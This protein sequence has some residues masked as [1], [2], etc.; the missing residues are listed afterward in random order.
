MQ[1]Q[2]FH[3][4]VT[5]RLLRNITFYNNNNK[6]NNNNNNNNKRNLHH[7]IT[8]TYLDF[9][10]FV[11]KKTQKENFQASVT[12]TRSHKIYVCASNNLSFTAQRMA[13]FSVSLSSVFLSISAHT[14][15][16]IQT[17][18]LT[19]CCRSVCSPCWS[20]IGRIHVSSPVLSHVRACGHKHTRVSACIIGSF[21][22]LTVHTAQTAHTDT[23]SPSSI[24]SK[25]SRHVREKIFT[26]CFLFHCRL[27]KTFVLQW[28][29]K[30]SRHAI[31]FK[32]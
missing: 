28:V 5:K 2:I 10:P 13:C 15:T 21:K 14:H 31:D 25:Q 4:Q 8:L 1:W 23:T 26:D 11:G 29:N 20:D 27:W 22:S 18:T 12:W 17:H 6:N 3:K 7:S 32:S 16:H 9:V 19:S 30:L 24:N